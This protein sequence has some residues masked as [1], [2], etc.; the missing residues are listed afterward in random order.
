MAFVDSPANIKQREGALELIV[1]DLPKGAQLGEWMLPV[2]RGFLAYADRDQDGRRAVDRFLERFGHGLSN[3]ERAA[4][5]ALQEA[6]ASVFEVEA[7]AIG[8]GLTLRDRVRGERVEIREVSASG[9]LVRGDALFAWLMRV[10]DHV[11]LTGAAM[12]IPAP[13]VE[14]LV[15]LVRHELELGRRERGQEPPRSL[16]GEVAGIV[17]VALAE[18]M[19]AGRPKYVTTHGEDLVFC[20]AHYEVRD[21]ERLRARLASQPTLEPQD[22]EGD[23]YAWLDRRPNKRLGGGPTVLGRIRHDTR[24]LVLETQSR[25]RLERGRAL[26][27]RLAGNAIVHK[28]DTFTDIEAKLREPRTPRPEP[29][30]PPEVQAQVLGPYL[31]EQYLT[32]WVREPIPALGGRTPRAAARSKE[33]RAQ[34]ARLIDEAERAS[35][36]MPGGDDPA[37]WNELR[38]TLKIP[39]RVP[40]GL[41]LVYDADRAPD[42]ADWLAADEDVRIA[43]VRAYHDHLAAQ[44]DLPA[45]KMHALMHVIVENQLAAGEPPEAAAALARLCAAGMSRHAAIHAVASVVAEEMHAVMKDDRTYDRATTARRLERLRATDGA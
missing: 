1:Q 13:H 16:V 12:S 7:V 19:A 43:A 27:H 42:A 20:E 40:E 28:V 32:R 34:V 45:P 25:E 41:G 9:H 30:I 29:E 36:D 14:P 10:D 26:L 24:T 22:T 3:G 21:V 23:D 31:R 17:V 5:A 44:P 11:E 38:T 15:A 4:L 18:L 35:V 6:W 2:I 33:G 37:L 39:P 8:A